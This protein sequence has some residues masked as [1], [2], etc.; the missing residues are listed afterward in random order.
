MTPPSAS[1][2]KRADLKMTFALG[3]AVVAAVAIAI[4]TTRTTH[5]ADPH[6]E[7]PPLAAALAPAGPADAPPADDS[8]GLNGEVLETLPVSKYTYLRLRTAD[9]EVWAAV[10]TASVAVGSRV[11]IGNATRMADFKS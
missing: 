10:P 1:H 5:G 7:D 4:A 11:A 2:G 6:L 9:G 8:A 3:G